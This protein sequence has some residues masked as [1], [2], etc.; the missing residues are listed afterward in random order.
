MSNITKKIFSIEQGEDGPVS[1]E[2]TKLDTT[3]KGRTKLKLTDVPDFVTREPIEPLAAPPAI[4]DEDIE[5]PKTAGW[6]IL[7]FGLLYLIGAGLYFGQPL[8]SEPVKMLSIAGLALLLLLPVFLLFLLWRSLRHLN[9]ISQQNSR[10]SKAAA[11]LVSPDREALAR[12]ESLASGIQKQISHVNNEMEQTVEALKNVQLAV[13]RESQALDAAGVALSNRSDSVGRN[14]TLQRQALESMSGTF[15]T[16]M[17]TLA[18]QIT[19][20]GQTLEG[21][22]TSAET[23][24]LAASEALQ[25]AT[26]VVDETVTSSASKMVDNITSL[27]EANQKLTE[28]TGTITS[29]LTA[30]TETLRSTDGAFAENT[31]KLTELAAQ[32]QTQISDLQATIG[33]GYEVL[34]D[35]RTESETRASAVT[36]YYDEL[37]AQIKRSEDE[38]L[39]AQGETANMVQSNL[40]QI[41]RDFSRME[42]DLQ[43]LQYKLNNLRHSSD[44][45]PDPEPTTTRL[46]LMPLETDF[47]PVEPPRPKVTAKR[48]TAE[49]FP[50]NLGMDME[51]ESIDEP[52]INFEPEVIRRPGTAKTNSKG[53][54]F[55]RRSDKEE[56]SGWR[57]RDML[58]SLERPDA[59]ISSAALAPL[60]SSQQAVDGVSL[61][62]QL[63]LSPAAIVDEGTVIEATQA[64]MNN[65]DSGL[66]DV[67]LGKLPEA[68]AHLKDNVKADT[69]LN[70]KLRSFTMDFAKKLNST[71]SSAP[72]LRAA[73]GSPEGRAYLLCAAAFKPGLR[74]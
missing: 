12:T 1:A 31:E 44:N 65:G 29:D 4:L 24:L 41:R 13:S 18:T 34:S 36:S 32:T 73:L 8:L 52:L 35:L 56:K 33:H 3:D 5:E 6:V 69:A 64:R 43:S 7:G 48:V 60:S 63:K 66:T 67:V 54:G 58:G 14:L 9:V 72:A 62:T 21:I 61:L 22:C 27:D 11:I 26:V 10:L 68:V 2:D 28:T 39:A 51:L 30:S 46:N 19:D 71:P 49:D 42:T 23:K 59:N 55:G 53:K 40:A 15:D 50:L 20:S 74:G 17:S 37:S 70:A 25:K 57:W 45:L 38:A 47:P 16:R